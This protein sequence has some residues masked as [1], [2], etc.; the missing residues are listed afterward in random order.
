[1]EQFLDIVTLWA[2]AVLLVLSVVNSLTEHYSK[3]N[4]ILRLVMAVIERLSVLASKETGR[5]FKAP[6]ASVKPD[7]IMERMADVKKQFEDL[8]KR[9]AAHRSPL[10]RRGL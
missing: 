2:P 3:F 5:R 6:G 4:G 9:K 8:A 7:P 10:D 1:M